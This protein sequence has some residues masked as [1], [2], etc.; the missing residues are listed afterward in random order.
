MEADKVK[1]VNNKFLPKIFGKRSQLT[2]LDLQN[3]R[4]MQ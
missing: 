3:N 4:M 1:K 2:N